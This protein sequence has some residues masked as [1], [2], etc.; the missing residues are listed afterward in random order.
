MRPFAK[1]LLYTLVVVMG[2]PLL[3]FGLVAIR[4]GFIQWAATRA[5]TQHPELFEAAADSMVKDGIQ[6]VRIEPNGTVTVRCDPEQVYC[7]Y[8]SQEV[9]EI[10]MRLGFVFVR[11]NGKS[12]WFAREAGYEFHKGVARFDHRPPS[13]KG[14]KYEYRQLKGK[15]YWYIE[16]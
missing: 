6:F 9:L 2:V 5:F 10:Q 1:A 8:P 4:W 15:W 16:A 12:V 11:R 14:D 3:L 7:P 13:V